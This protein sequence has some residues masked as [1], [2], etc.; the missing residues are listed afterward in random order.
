MSNESKLT[1]LLNPPK[2]TLYPYS[3]VRS[4][5][6]YKINCPTPFPLIQNMLKI[7]LLPPLTL[8][9]GSPTYD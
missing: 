6:P 9:Q 4:P 7:F 1:S 5:A 8:Q 3:R 2:Q